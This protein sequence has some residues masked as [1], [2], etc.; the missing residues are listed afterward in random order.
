MCVFCCMYLRL[1]VTNSLSRSCACVYVYLSVF[2]LFVST[3]ASVIIHQ[4]AP[5]CFWPRDAGQSEG[6]G[7]VTS[8]PEMA[9]EKGRCR[10]NKVSPWQFFFGVYDS[11][12]FLI[13]SLIND[14]WNSICD[15]NEHYSRYK[16][17]SISSTSFKLGPN[18]VLAA[19]S[20]TGLILVV[21]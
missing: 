9:L 2:T 7:H 18:F 5:P 14:L 15:F 6:G 16:F 11:T 20:K 10:R 21:A 19:P 3:S 8:D 17:G 1:L 13:V 4:S 12:I